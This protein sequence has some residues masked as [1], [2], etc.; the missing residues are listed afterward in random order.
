V[1]GTLLKEMRR[2]AT[3]D[4]RLVVSVG[5]HVPLGTTASWLIKATSMHD[6]TLVD[7]VRAAV[8]VVR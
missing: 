8:R 1:N 4:Y 7:A 5:K 6:P 2:G 3:T